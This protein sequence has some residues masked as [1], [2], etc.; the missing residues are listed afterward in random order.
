MIQTT[1][2]FYDNSIYKYRNTRSS[3]TIDVFDN[4][5]K[6]DISTLSVN[7]YRFYNQQ[8]LIDN[9]KYDEKYATGELNEFKLNGSMTLLPND[10]T[11]KQ[12]G[13]WTNLGNANGLFTTNPTLTINLDNLHST[14]GL[15]FIYDEFSY[16][17]KS[18]AYWY[19]NSTL[20]QS[21]ELNSTSNIQVFDNPCDLYNK[22]VLEI[23][24]VKPYAYAKLG[25]L[26]FGITTTFDGD[27]LQ[28][29]KITEHCSIMSNT[30]DPNELEFKIIDYDETYNLFNTE[31]L[32]K[33]FKFG[34]KCYVNAGVYVKEIKEYE[35][36]S[37]GIYYI[38]TPNKDKGIL[39]IKA[40]GL[41]NLLNSQQFYSPFY[42]NETVKNI[43]DD[44]LEDYSYYVHDNVKN[45][46]LTG[47][48]PR[49]TKKEALKYVAIAS[50][51]IIKEGRDGK[52]YI[53]QAT[54]DFSTNQIVSDETIYEQYG[55][56]NILMAGDSIIPRVQIPKPFI[57]TVTREQRL[58]D[59]KSSMIDVYN[60][61]DVTYK[62]YELEQTSELYNETIKTDESGQAIIEYGFP[63]S[64]ESVTTT[65]SYENYADCT[66]ITGT[67]LTDYSVV[68]SGKKYAVNDNVMSSYTN[69]QGA[70]DEA[71]KT[72]E[73]TSCNE[74]IT[75]T[76]AKDCASWYLTSLQ[77]RKDIE[78][79]WWSIATTEASDFINVITS[80]N[81]NEQMQINEMKY[82]LYDL[83]ATVKGVC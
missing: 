7:D 13:W 78:F 39:T 19:N 72:M 47:Y 34:Q 64:V 42:T 10:I 50:G 4:T 30:I 75:S 16:P 37:M 54:P 63:V 68:V 29:A 25:E 21:Y 6:Q 33:Y 52:I 83:I 43:L 77:K 49:T 74:L 69:V 12:I 3:I 5:A 62:N 17:L 67:P 38:D 28:G 79:D 76:N 22:V 36:I 56:A 59:I 46:L 45:K 11:N 71:K 27:K 44:I 9:V 24:Q 1:Q 65:A 60:R 2:S 53:Y 55:M 41:L 48:I 31:N 82:D 18:K 73:L 81:T 32:V 23:I 40:Y 35:D 15:T 8:Q 80:F 14:I 51:S 58:S 66:I 26:N 61:C 70:Y 57:F 20:I